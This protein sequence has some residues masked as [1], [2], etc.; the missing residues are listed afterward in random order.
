[1]C[2]ISYH[3]SHEQFAPSELLQYVQLAELAGFDGCHSSDQ[4][5]PWSEQQGQSGFAFAW[6][7]AAMQS[8]RFPFSM[9]TAP[10]QRY[11]PAIVAQ[12]ICTLLQ[13]F[14]DR[15]EVALGSGEAINEKITGDGWPSKAERNVRLKECAEIMRKLFLGE[16][17]SYSGLVKIQEAK[18]YTRPLNAPALMCAALSMETAKWAA[19]WADGL[20]TVAQPHAQMRDMI[21]VFRDNGGEGKPIHLQVS[22]SYSCDPDFAKQDAYYQFRNNAL[23]AS[24]LSD[25]DSVNKFD[26][27]GK[28]ITMEQLAQ[29]IR[30]SSSLSEHL[31]MLGKD[32]ELG[33]DN[34]ILHNV[35]SGQET[36]IN[37]FGK[38]VLPVLKLVTSKS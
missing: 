35:N 6:L 33:F 28:A 13:M 34:I 16:T 19:S 38:E 18:L 9:V 24:L 3:A 23:D 1:M 32:V 21:N 25:I 31:D 7:G 20:L 12:A 30:I 11:H 29:K 17:V 2:S 8:T 15:L 4:F 5:H 27:L 14:P 36:F 10:S 37:H 22:L 26:E